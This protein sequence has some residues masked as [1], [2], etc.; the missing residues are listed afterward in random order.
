M[1]YTESVGLSKPVVHIVD[2][3]AEAVRQVRRWQRRG[4]Q[5]LIRAQDIRLV[6]HD[7]RE[8]LLT[9]VMNQLREQFEVRREVDYRGQRA[10]QPVAKTTVVLHR[11][12]KVRRPQ[13]QGRQR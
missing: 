5:F 7:G 11:P 4:R 2:R 3:E 10:I 13:T 1:G 12:A 9:T 8:V 6:H